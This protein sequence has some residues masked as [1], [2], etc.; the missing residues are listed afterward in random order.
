MPGI[1]YPQTSSA[2]STIILSFAHCFFLGKRIAFL[3]RSEAALRRQTELFEIG[4]LRRF[5]D[6]AL[7]CVLAFQLAGFGRHQAKHR[8]TAFLQPFQRLKAAGTGGV[9]FHKVAVHL[10]AVEQNF[11]HRIVTAAAH[12]GRFV[13]AT[14][15]MHRHRHVGG[16]IRHRFV[17]EIGVNAGQIVGVIAAVPHLLAIF[18]IAQHGDEHF[19]ELYVAASGVGESPHRFFVGLTKIGEEC[20]EVRVDR[21][22]DRCPYRPAI[23]R[24]RRGNRHFRRPASMR[25]EKFEV[26]QHRM[27]GKTD[28][29]G[30][31]H[32]FIAGGDG[33]KS[34]TA[35]HHVTLDAI[36]TPQEI[37]M[38]PRAA[39]LAV[40]D[41]LQADRLLLFDDVFDRAVFHDL[42]RAGRDLA[43]GVAF[44]R[45]SKRC[46]PQQAADMIGTKWRFGSLRHFPHT[47]SAISTI[48]RSFAHCSSSDRT[49]PS[50]VEAKPH[51]GDR[52]S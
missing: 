51:C 19:V 44:A 41:C 10:D 13:V 34:D 4:E 47:S 35:I 11:L 40:A 39:E 37:E 33:G 49:L 22:V 50:S 43:F 21:L 20:I 46:R 17:D 38:P 25:F 45:I 27:A 16:N 2:T 52:Q 3:G 42:Q 18:R 12:E 30:D 24:G 5:L 8:E 15:Q 36:E 31:A 9:I 23:E 28:L 48:M 32:A 14:A 26:L 1:G 7:D 6:P 29:A